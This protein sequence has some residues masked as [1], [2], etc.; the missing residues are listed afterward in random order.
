MITGES[1][2]FD[3]VISQISESLQFL[4]QYNSSSNLYF[5]SHLQQSFIANRIITG[6]IHA[7]C[8]WPINLRLLS[9]YVEE[10]INFAY[11]LT[12]YAVHIVRA[13]CYTPLARVQHSC[14]QASTHYKRITHVCICVYHAHVIVYVYA[15]DSAKNTVRLLGSEDGGIDSILISRV[16]DRDNGVQLNLSFLPMRV[17]VNCFRSILSFRRTHQM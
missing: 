16:C 7:L 2:K 17:Y 3:Q 5:L 10:S 14:V 8:T 6:R 1:T 9:L 15:Y 13:A 11:Q 12:T 4:Q